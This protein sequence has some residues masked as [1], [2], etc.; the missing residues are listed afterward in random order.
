MTEHPTRAHAHTH[1]HTQIL[2]GMKWYFIKILICIFLVANDVKHLGHCVCVCV[3]TCTQ[4]CV[5]VCVHV[6]GHVQLFAIPLTVCNSPSS[7]VNRIFSV[8]VLEWAA[9]S[10]YRGSF[11]YLC[12]IVY[13]DPLPTFNWFIF[14]L[15]GCKSSSY[16]HKVHY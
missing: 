1:T 10:F 3:C 16:I 5:C 8:R 11:V 15:L 4:A 12:R 6:I 7:S 9:I 2:V 13:T 14:L